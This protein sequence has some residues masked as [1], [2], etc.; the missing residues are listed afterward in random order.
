M[1]LIISQKKRK[2]IIMNASKKIKIFTPQKFRKGILLLEKILIVLMVL[3]SF[4]GTIWI[5]HP[6]VCKDILYMSVYTLLYFAIFLVLFNAYGC[7]KIGSVRLKELLFSF[8]LT[9]LIADV[10]AYFVLVL[11]KHDLQ[12]VLPFLIMLG[13]QM[14]LGIV[15]YIVA[16]ATY[17][18]LNPVFD[19]VAICA[20]SEWERNSIRKFRAIPQRYQITQ[21]LSEQ[22]TEQEMLDA[23]DHHDSVILGAL[24]GKLRTQLMDYCFAHNK[25][26]Y[27]LPHVQDIVINA[28]QPTQIGDMVVMLC[29][30]RPMTVEQMF[31]K[32]LMDIVISAVILLVTAP[33]VGIAALCIKLYDGGPVIFRQKRYTRNQ[34]VFTMYKLR[35]MI[36][37]AEKDG[38]QRT[39]VGDKRITPIGKF[40]RATRLDEIPQLVNVL[41]GDMAI[42]GPRAESIGLVDAYI[43]K[44]P[45]FRYRTKVKAGLT[46]YAQ[47][48]GK[49]NT[50]HEDKA[51]MDIYYIENYSLLTDIKL[52]LYT[53]KVIFMKE[54]TEGFDESKPDNM[55]E[56]EK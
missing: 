42:V 43:E 36:V 32:R 54:S 55:Q 40:I 12:R 24:E 16:N 45:A 30:N 29:K 51:R 44:M 3:A 19:M 52:L 49:A 2:I 8:G 11:L 9:L 26:V 50:S 37:D 17:F 39:T 23:I 20:D 21:I 13:I 1:Y 7:P 14:V 56:Q 22:N 31:I 38:E 34:E 48:Y 5:T 33:F 35:S 27:V 4:A 15:L 41:K 47:V 6:E 18:S 25:R 10:F 28:A 53:V 46:G